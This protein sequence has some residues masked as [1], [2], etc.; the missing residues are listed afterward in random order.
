MNNASFLESLSGEIVDGQYLWVNAFATSPD[1]A[2]WAGRP[3]QHKTAQQLLI[4][5]AADQNTYFCPALLSGLD[6]GLF[7]RTKSQFNRLL[8]LVADDADPDDVI[9][10]LSWLIETSTNNFQM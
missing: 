4:N 9:G 8:A 10:S 5:E 1:K 3:Y 2:Q 7:K 6:N